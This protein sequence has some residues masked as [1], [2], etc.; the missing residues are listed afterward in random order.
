VITL[1]DA[2]TTTVAIVAY[3][4]PHALARLLEA[5]ADPALDVIVVNVGGDAEVAR[6]AREACTPVRVIAVENR[7][8]A[9]AVNAGAAAARGDV[10]VF[11]NDDVLLTADA[12]A[13]LATTI[14]S[15]GA[16]VALPRVVTSDGS[17]VGTALALPTPD[18]LL[19]E[20]A[21]LPDRP[22]AVLNGRLTIEKWRRP[23][24]TQEIK[25]GTAAAVAARRDV[26]RSTPLPEDYFLYWEELE[27]FWRLHER[28]NGVVLVPDVTVVHDG[29]RDDVRA[30]KS[31]RL[32]RNAVRCVRRTQGWWAALL[33]YPIV[34]VWN[35]RLLM[36][37]A[38][39][40]VLHQ[41]L[42]SRTRLNARTAG[43][44]AALGSWKELL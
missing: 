37:D 41:R 6:V 29:G 21:L 5:V 32:A 31:R 38:A 3:R 13:R 22:V 30:A 27:W 43:F 39:R 36:V 18:R 15:G 17:D 1:L 20:W 23:S 34:I 35:A 26:L 25:A 2:P 14:R 12:V 11:T 28:A 19:V 44:V 42:V 7:G 8:Y 10:V 24:A 16:D 33:A 4:R 40:S 9:A